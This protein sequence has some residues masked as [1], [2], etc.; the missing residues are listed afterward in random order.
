MLVRATP[1]LLGL[2]P[3]FWPAIFD[4]VFYNSIQKGKEMVLVEERRLL[5]DLD[6]F[7]ILKLYG[8]HQQRNPICGEYKWGRHGPSTRVCREVLCTSRYTAH[9]QWRASRTIQ[10]VGTYFEAIQDT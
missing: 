9:Q 10:T 5:V 3:V 1:P 4:N 6:C 7:E 2:L 8:P